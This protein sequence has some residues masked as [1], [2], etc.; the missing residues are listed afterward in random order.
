MYM[1]CICICNVYIYIHKYI[2]IS[3]YLCNI[4]ICICIYIEASKMMDLRVF[5]HQNGGLLQQ[6]LRIQAA[7]RG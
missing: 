1:I 3:I 7:K 2:Y 4:H 5:K 6:K